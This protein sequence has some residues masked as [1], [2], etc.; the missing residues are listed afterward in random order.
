MAEDYYKTLG[1][2]RTASEAEIKKA[3]RKLAMKYHPDHAKGDKSAEDR[4]K[5]ISE[6]YAVLSDKEKR[7]E[8]DTFGSEGFRQRFSQED[9]FR[10]FDFND[11]LREFGFGGG[12]PLGGRAGGSRFTFRTGSPYETRTRHPQGL[13]GADLVYELPLTLREAAFGA[14]KEVLIQNQGVPE[15]VTVKIPKGMMSG[16]KL[17]LAGKGNPGSYGGPRGDL[18]IQADVMEDPVF[19]VQE[20]NL[21]THREI[22]LTEA[23]MGTTI[24]VPTLEDRQLNLKVPAGTRSGTKLRLAEHGLPSMKGG[25]RG[26]LYVTVHVQIPKNLTA[27]Q[28]ALVEKLA[29]TGL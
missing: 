6:A 21:V 27:E 8:Y 5:K 10:G 17:R 1:V 12:E 18:Y 25:R 9:I 19:S 11:I 20:Q 4:F 28:A 24:S 23:L 16:K 7:R 22:K 29:E 14:T 3:Y 15:R 26:D 13:K 2:G